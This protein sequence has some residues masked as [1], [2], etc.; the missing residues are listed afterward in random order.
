MKFHRW[1]ECAAA[2]L[3]LVSP[4]VAQST[5]TPQVIPLPSGAGDIPLLQGRPQT[6]GMRSGLV[7]LQPNQT[8]GWHTT[9][10]HEEALVILHGQG[11]ALIEGQKDRTFVAPAVTYIPP[12]TRHNVKNTGK[13]VL[14]YV[15][16][17]APVT[18]K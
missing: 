14:E 3:L 8:V 7:R 18:Q 9:G 12:G 1:I 5:P 4:S 13:D 6:A 17:V 2:A 16:V 11:A 10:Q 15:Y